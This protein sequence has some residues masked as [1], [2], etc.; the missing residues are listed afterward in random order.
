[1]GVW[2]DFKTSLS[3]VIKTPGVA[4]DSAQKA[5][6]DTANSYGKITNSMAGMADSMD[7]ASHGMAN[8]VISIS[9]AVDQ[10]S[11]IAPYVFIG[12]AVIVGVGAVLYVSSIT[13]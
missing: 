2:D 10:I 7:Q 4:A 6:E 1:M 13:S 3:K 8:C 9:R 12:G 5:I 11:A